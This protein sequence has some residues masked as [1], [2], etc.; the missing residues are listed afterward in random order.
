MPTKSTLQTH[1]DRGTRI[2]KGDNE[3]FDYPIGVALPRCT[4]AVLCPGSWM[5]VG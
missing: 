4:L 1:T 2:T 3:V 5:H